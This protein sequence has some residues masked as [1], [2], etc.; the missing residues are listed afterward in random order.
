MDFEAAARAHQR[1]QKIE[2]VM[3]WRD[4][5][6]RDLEELH[7]IAIAPS[8]WPE[9]VELGWMRAGFWHGFRRLDFIAAEDG[10]AV[11]LD[12]RLRELAGSIPDS[13]PPVTNTERMEHLAILSRWFYSSWCDGELLLADTWEKISWRKVVNAVS[14]IAATQRKGR[15]S[16][17]S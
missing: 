10:R 5:M 17:S 12:S 14:R 9:S 15:P 13:P 7:A 6:A 16:T 2:E 3:G 4:E 8:A 1:I 11:S